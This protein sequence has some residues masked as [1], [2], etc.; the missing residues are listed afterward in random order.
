MVEER[1]ITMEEVGDLIGLDRSTIYNWKR[2]G[3]LPHYKIGKR[4]VR[5][6][7]SEIL[8]WLETWKRNTEP[9]W[10]KRSRIYKL[11]LQENS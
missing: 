10:K 11:Y 1:L 6:K 4:A 3:L 7:L 9:R 5:F 8:Q 2:R